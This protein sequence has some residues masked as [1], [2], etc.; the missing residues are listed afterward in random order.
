MRLARLPFVAALAAAALA[1]TA[2]A[3]PT[4]SGS[5]DSGGATIEH[6]LGTT[7]LPADP[8]RV[9]T[10]GW[11]A[12]DAAL[13]LGVMP[14]GIEAQSYGAD[15]NGVMPWNAEK[16][17]ELGGAAPT[18]IPATV[19]APAYEA[20]AALEPDLILAPY[21]GIDQAQYE[22]LSEIAPTVAYPGEPWAT[23][24]RD[25]IAMVGTSLGK[26]D[27]ASALVTSIEGE[28]ATAAAAHPEFAGKTVSMVW[29]VAGTLYVYK[30]ADPRVEFVT[31]LGFTSAPAVE[32]LANGEQT[33]F[34]TLST[35]KTSELESDIVVAFADTQADLDAFLAQPYAQAMPAVKAGAVAGVVG[36]SLVAS[37]S[38][39]TALSLTWGMEPYLTAL[40][41]AV[42]AAPVA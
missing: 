11:G 3:G 2:C 12:T 9:V 1:L 39:P 10:L 27:A 28:I 36:Q 7:Q 32:A 6:A 14:I 35:E 8:Q 37:V 20:I 21:S 23:P 15:A 18:V 29:D 26:A 13:A 33:F 24:W 22:L 38:P 40:T 31:D 34:Y 19:E 42:A 17:A 5:P 16:I 30:P 25:V 41:T 4:A